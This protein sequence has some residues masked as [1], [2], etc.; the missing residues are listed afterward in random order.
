M[1]SAVRVAGRRLYDYA[2]QGEVIDRP[3]RPIHIEHL[4]RLEFSGRRLTLEVTCSKGTYVRTLAQ[5][6]GRALGCGA[7]LVELRR[8]RVAMFTLT[9][10]TP[11]QSLEAEGIEV[12][13]KN[14]LPAHVLVSALARFD[15]TPEE[16]L[17][18]GHGRVIE[19]GTGNSQADVAVFGADGR[20]LGVG[21]E[22]SAG[23]IAPLRLMAGA[24]PKYP[25]FS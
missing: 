24:A 21:R 18:F 17:R 3:S 13:R 25:D 16:A 5:D 9:Q 8:T 10:A 23:T 20:F 1:H 4:A 2:R 7:Y 11:L 22:L 19:R 12:A 6:I 14:L 15:A